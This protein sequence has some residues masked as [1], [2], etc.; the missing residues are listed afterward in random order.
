MKGAGGVDKYLS[1]GRGPTRGDSGGGK[2]EEATRRLLSPEKMD[3]RAVA[4][5]C[6]LEGFEGLLGTSR[7]LLMAR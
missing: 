7:T 1:L 4:F 2:E 3:G 6:G 5:E